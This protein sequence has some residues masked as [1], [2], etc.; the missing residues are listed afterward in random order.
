MDT[1][2]R[3]H[4][5]HVTLHWLIAIGIFINLYLGIIVFEQQGGGPADFQARNTL[6]VIHMAVGISILLLLLIRFMMRL[7]VK[8]PAEATAG[9]QFLDTLAKI[10]H[11][12]LYITVLAVT[13]IGLTFSLQTGRFQSAFLGAESQF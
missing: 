13:V 7:A 4:P 11:Y 12:G 6:Q 8:R 1:P 5:I 3:Y 10:V 2:R 9:N